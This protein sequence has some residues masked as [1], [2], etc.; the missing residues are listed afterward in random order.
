MELLKRTRRFCNWTVFLTVLPIIF[1]GVLILIKSVNVPVLDQWEL[2]PVIE[3]TQ[4]GHLT[5]GDF[6]KQHNEHRIFFPQIVMLASA[7]VTHWNTQVECFIGLA[8]AVASFVLLV[9]IIKQT[10]ALSRLNGKLLAL[11]VFMAS[12]IWF[13]PVQMEN[14]L[15]GW[16]IQWFMNVFGVVLTAYCL[17]KINRSTLSLKYLALILSGGILAQYSLGNGTLIWPIVIAVLIYKKIDRQKIML[18]AGTGIATTALYYWQ[19]VNSSQFSKTLA[20]HEPISYVNYVLTYF[21]RPLTFFHRLAAFLGLI[22]LIIFLGLNF[23]LF[24]KQRKLFNTLIPWGVLGFYAIGSGVITG[25]ARLDLGVSEA[26]SSRYATISSLLL[27]S[28]LVMLFASRKIIKGLIG[29]HYDLLAKTVV[30]STTL[31]IMA[32]MAWGV[33]SANSRSHELKSS[34]ECTH[35]SNPSPECL[36]LTYPNVTVVA[37][38]LNYLK[39]IHWAGY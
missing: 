13:S 26:Y 28:C 27:L 38:R 34:R 12:L 29:R 5:L 23:Y 15:W 18:V 16:Q 22:S 17:S 30:A 9:K 8:I 11:L 24:T 19:Y 10:T 37:D 4:T 1:I 32:N 20:I 7:L 36:L 3:H 31:L 39:Q 21:G 6:W 33:H 14:W 35:L 25:L 2:V